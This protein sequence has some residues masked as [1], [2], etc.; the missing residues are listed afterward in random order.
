MFA[1]LASKLLER[2]IGVDHYS[3]STSM[4]EEFEIRLSQLF[5]QARRHPHRAIFVDVHKLEEDLAALKKVFD[6]NIIK[7]ESLLRTSLPQRQASGLKGD[8]GLPPEL[9]LLTKNIEAAEN[10]LS[11]IK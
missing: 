6:E 8:Q 1:A 9:V 2:Q 4:P 3:T 10:I 11:V 5:Y 7:I